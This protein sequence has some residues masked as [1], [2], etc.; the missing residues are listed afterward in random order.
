MHTQPHHLI[1]KA[2]ARGTATRLHYLQKSA[3]GQN[4]D[5]LSEIMEDPTQ[6]A[7]LEF[8]RTGITSLTGARLLLGMGFAHFAVHE[9]SKGALQGL[10]V[11]TIGLTPA[12]HILADKL[13]T[14]YDLAA[15][16]RRL[17]SYIDALPQDLRYDQIVVSPAR[18][19]QAL[20]N[21]EMPIL[22]R[23]VG[24]LVSYRLVASEKFVE[25][26]NAL[27]C[28]AQEVEDAERLALQ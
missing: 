25:D 7:L 27:T 20:E 10:H 18:L 6:L 8:A 12:A 9:E 11:Q 2:V 28:L 16:A 22:N 14:G 1:A 13:M 15:R 3:A 26:L 5:L 21:L 19:A 23:I 17:V 4:F 24:P